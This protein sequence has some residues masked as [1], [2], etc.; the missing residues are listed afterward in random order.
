MTE[1]QTDRTRTTLRSDG[2]WRSLQK[3]ACTNDLTGID[4]K[5]FVGWFQP[6]SIY[7][8]K[9]INAGSNI[10]RVD[11]TPRHARLD[12]LEDYSVIFQLT[13]RSAIDQSDK[14]LELGTGDLTLFDPVRQTTVFNQPG[15]VHHMALHL[16]R[17]ELV[18][19]L[20][21]E[22]KGPL[23]R[24]GTA[25][26]RLLL[27]LMTETLR[28]S[29]PSGALPEAQMRLVVY[30]LFAALFTPPGSER[31]SAYTD[32]LF[33]RICKMMQARLADPDLTPSAVAAEARI[34]IRYLQKL[35]SARGT[36]CGHYIHSLRLDQASRLLHRRSL[37]GSGEPLGEIAFACGFLDYPHFSRK[38][39][40]RFGHS[41]SAHSASAVRKSTSN[42][43]LSD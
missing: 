29:G 8:F 22:P 7:G 18:A 28:E 12:G 17:R 36:T 25:A 40:E 19:H 27:Q 13:G 14:L 21:F 41:P 10:G 38:F 3:L 32:K 1:A 31:V 11:R 33:A 5:S 15:V 9:A 37:S 42:M 43:A 24:G 4:P 23:H 16:P 2:E 30:D 20:G 26:N 39:R 34:S 6:F 35:F